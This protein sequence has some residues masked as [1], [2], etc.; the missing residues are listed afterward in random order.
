MDVKNV[1]KLAN[2]P[3]TAKE[4]KKF[5]KQFVQTLETIAII[6]ELDT[7]KVEPTSQVTGLKNVIRTDKVD[8]SRILKVGR[9]FKVPAIFDAQ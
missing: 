7:S 2:L 3:L 6:N 1:A 8:E 4:E 9:Y 5:Q